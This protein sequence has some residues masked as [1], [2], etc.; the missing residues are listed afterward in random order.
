MTIKASEISELI[1]KKIE[2]VQNHPFPQTDK[3]MNAQ[4]K[5]EFE[6]E[7]QRKKQ[8]FYANRNKKRNAGNSNFRNKRR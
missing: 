6:K 1:K 5:K 2:A 8:E 4:Q 3:P 7:K